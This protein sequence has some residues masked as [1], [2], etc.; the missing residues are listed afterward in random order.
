MCSILCWILS[1]WEALGWFFYIFGLIHALSTRGRRGSLFQAIS[2]LCCAPVWPI[3]VT[4]LTSQSAGPVHMLHTGLTG[5]VDRSDRWCRPVWP[6]RAELMQLLC[7]FKW[8]ACI[9][10]GGVALVQGELACVQGELWF[11]GLRSLLK[12]SFVS[13]VSSRCPCLRGLRFVFFKW[14]F[15]L[16]FFGFRSLVGVSFYSFLFFFSLGLLYVCVVNALIKGR[17]RTMCG[18]RTGGCSLP[19]VMS[20]WQ[21]CVDWFLAKYCRCRLRLD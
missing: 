9:H 16:P 12:H 4:S 20:D 18:S 1:I 6:V 11:G 13:D 17:L 10:P 15:S 14:S 3:E 7:F 19:G 8:F 5:G 21:R 2:G